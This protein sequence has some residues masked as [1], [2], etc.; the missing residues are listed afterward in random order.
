[1]KNKN[2]V[3]QYFYQ[4]DFSILEVVLLIIAIISLIVA[5][6][7][8]GGGPIGFPALLICIVVFCIYRSFKI[9]DA[10]IDRTLKK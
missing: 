8:Q 5:T 9:K 6:F 1:M 2:T 10:E 7:V 3:E 4:K